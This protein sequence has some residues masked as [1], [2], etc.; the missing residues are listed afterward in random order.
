M[1]CVGQMR[2]RCETECEK[3]VQRWGKDA[4]HELFDPNKRPRYFERAKFPGPWQI[5]N[6]AFVLDDLH[7]QRGWRAGVHFA[8]LGGLGRSMSGLIGGSDGEDQGGEEQ[9]LSVSE[10]A[11]EKSSKAST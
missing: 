11:S 10:R 7:L 3:D 4:S 9:L 6:D 5:A 1:R 8:P 2:T